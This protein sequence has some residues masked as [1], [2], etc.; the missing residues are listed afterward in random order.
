MVTFARGDGGQGGST[1]EQAGVH[2]IPA[3]TPDLVADFTTSPQA[4]LLY[5]LAGD[6]NPLHADPKVAAVAGYDAPILHGLCTFGVAC[7]RLV[8]AACGGDASRVRSLSCRFTAPVYPG[9][10]IRTA[11]WLDGP[12]VSFRSSIPARGV[13]VLDHGRAEVT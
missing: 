10:T 12:V 1:R 5:R 11:L 9:E 4:G 13:T 7:H 3:R 2:A 8:D 6:L